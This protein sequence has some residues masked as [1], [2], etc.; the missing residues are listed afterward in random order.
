MLILLFFKEM[1]IVFDRKGRIVV[2]S[3]YMI[4]REGVFVVGDVVL[5]LLKVGRV[6]KDGLYVVEFIYLWLMGR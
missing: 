1:G 2:D 6:V 3:R 5:G 4:S